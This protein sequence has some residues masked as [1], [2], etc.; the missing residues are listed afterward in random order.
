M[1]VL[2][3][4]RVFEG[5]NCDII[6]GTIRAFSKVEEYRIFILY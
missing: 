4:L 5:F 1:R 2:K 3:V 6:Y